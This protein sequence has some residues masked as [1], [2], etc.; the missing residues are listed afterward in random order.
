MVVQVV[1]FGDIKFLVVRVGIYGMC[2]EDVK[3]FHDLSSGICPED[4]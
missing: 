1:A 2:L 3:K 4:A